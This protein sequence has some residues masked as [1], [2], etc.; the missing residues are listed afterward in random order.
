MREVQ[1]LHAHKL[2]LPELDSSTV[3]FA[4]T[5]QDC[6][7]PSSP[8]WFGGEIRL[9]ASFLV[10]IVKAHTGYKQTLRTA[11]K[12][13]SLLAVCVYYRMFQLSTASLLTLKNNTASFLSVRFS[14][15]LPLFYPVP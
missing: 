3:C 6:C 12:E 1:R 8:A 13:S 14:A 11:F 10:W 15:P 9:Q 7:K 2:L 4:A 5:T